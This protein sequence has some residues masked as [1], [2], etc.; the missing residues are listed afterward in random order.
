MNKVTVYQYMVLGTNLG[1]RH[2]AGERVTRLRD[3]RALE[4]LEYT[5]ALVEVSS[6]DFNWVHRVGLRPSFRI[7]RQRR[8]LAF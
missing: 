3:S 5:A 2:A 7:G 6:V 4:I 8:S 1:A